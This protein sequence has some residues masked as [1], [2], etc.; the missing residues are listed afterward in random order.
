MECFKAIKKKI[1]RNSNT[2][3]LLADVGSGNGV[4]GLIWAICDESLNV[5]L[6]EKSAKKI[7]FLNHTIGVLKLSQR[8]TTIWDNVNKINT[9]QFD[10]ITSRAYSDCLKFLE[11]T[12]SISKKNSIWMIMTTTSRSSSLTKEALEKLSIE[13][14]EIIYVKINNE[15]TNKQIIFFKNK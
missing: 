4:P 13:V 14:N 1:Y 5:V 3:P 12:K 8:V 7:A 2:Y 15:K 6:I 9:V 11:S 10:I